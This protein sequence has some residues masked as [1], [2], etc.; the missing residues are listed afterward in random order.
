[1]LNLF[2]AVISVFFYNQGP[3]DGLHIAYQDESQQWQ[4][5]GQLLSSDYGA[6]G[7]EKRMFSPFI[8][9]MA[10]SRLSCHVCSNLSATSYH[11]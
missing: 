2:L 8:T 11:Y 5:I 7:Q 10:S 1:M 9:Q 6:W 3:N 4:E